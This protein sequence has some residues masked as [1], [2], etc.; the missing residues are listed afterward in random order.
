MDEI[1][2]SLLVRNKSLV[3]DVCYELG[4][5]VDFDLF[6]D[7][8]KK[9]D[10]VFRVIGLSD[11]DYY[12]LSFIL[13][14]ILSCSD[15]FYMEFSFMYDM[16]KEIALRVDVDVFLNLFKSEENK[17]CFLGVSDEKFNSLCFSVNDVRDIINYEKN[18]EK[19]LLFKL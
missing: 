10:N 16:F 7:L 19:K 9:G 17:L 12:S 14:D 6:C 3:F 5:F 15:A 18:L 4:M 2:N 1:N 8:F 11:E 13:D